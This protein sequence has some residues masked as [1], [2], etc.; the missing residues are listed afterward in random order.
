MLIDGEDIFHLQV[1]KLH[2]SFSVSVSNLFLI[3]HNLKR[4]LQTMLQRRMSVR[5]FTGGLYSLHVWLLLFKMVLEKFD[6]KLRMAEILTMVLKPNNKSVANAMYASP[7][8]LLY[9]TNLLVFQ[10]YL[11]SRCIHLWGSI[12]EGRLPAVQRSGYPNAS[13]SIR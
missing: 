10:L 9:A 12:F 4:L 2:V 8:Q 3:L 1:R 5:E 6:E 13:H 7:P 11:L